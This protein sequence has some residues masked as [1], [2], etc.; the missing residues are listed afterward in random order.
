MEEKYASLQDECTA[1]TAKLKEMW[2][3][4]QRTR[5]EVCGT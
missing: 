1:K 3:Q 2:K 4:Y 5:D